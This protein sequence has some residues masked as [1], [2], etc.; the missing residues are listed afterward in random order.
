MAYAESLRIGSVH[1]VSPDEIKVQLDIEA[2]D[3]VALNT[4]T[5]RPFPSH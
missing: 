2:P 3:T 5:A 1:F 4:G